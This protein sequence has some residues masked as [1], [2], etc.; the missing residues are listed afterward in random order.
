[1]S[2]PV[3]QYETHNPEI[4]ALMLDIAKRIGGVM[5]KGWGFMLHLFEFGTDENP[6]SSFYASSGDR[7]DS[8][9]MLKEWIAKSEA[10][11]R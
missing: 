3:I 11:L 9:R 10:R 2:G 1:M 4:Q 8:I 6:G 7:E 5:P